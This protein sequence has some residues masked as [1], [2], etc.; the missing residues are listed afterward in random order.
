MKIKGW[1]ILGIAAG[2]I[3]SFYEFVPRKAIK[4]IAEFLLFDINLFGH[5]IRHNDL[6]LFGALMLIISSV[7]LYKVYKL[8]KRKK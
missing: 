6:I 1:F 3:G 4:S 2:I 8:R 7:S 5:R